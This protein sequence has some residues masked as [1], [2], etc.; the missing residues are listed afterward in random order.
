M[1]KHLHEYE[2]HVLPYYFFTFFFR[3]SLSAWIFCQN[4]HLSIS[5]LEIVYNVVQ[6]ALGVVSEHLDAFIKHFNF[7][8]V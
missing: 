1:V 3:F 5:G 6:D 8:W 2:I 4:N 7:F